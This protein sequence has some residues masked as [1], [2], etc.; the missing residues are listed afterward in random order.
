MVLRNH[1]G[2]TYSSSQQSVPAVL[3][4]S[5]DGDDGPLECAEA[6]AT[7]AT[8]ADLQRQVQLLTAELAAAAANAAPPGGTLPPHAPSGR[9]EL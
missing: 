5:P 1:M 7:A 2:G 9:A 6:A 8:L 3:P 4:S